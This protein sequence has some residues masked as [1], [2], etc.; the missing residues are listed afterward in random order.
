VTDE[1]KQQIAKELKEAAQQARRE[2]SELIKQAR[3][4]QEKEMRERF[5]NSVGDYIGKQIRETLREVGA[6]QGFDHKMIGVRKQIEPSETAMK[7]LIARCDALARE[8]E[9]L[10]KNAVASGGYRDSEEGN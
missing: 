8:I 9:A 10:K 3:E 6:S 5:M 2:T 1:V 4:R 7:T